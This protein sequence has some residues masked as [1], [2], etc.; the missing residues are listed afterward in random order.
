MTIYVISLH[1]NMHPVGSYFHQPT[2]PRH[3]K[4]TQL[5]SQKHT[6]TMA[7]SERCVRGSVPCQSQALGS[8]G[9]RPW[10]PDSRDILYLFRFICILWC[11]SSVSVRSLSAF[12]V[13]VYVYVY[14]NVYVSIYIYVIILYMYILIYS[15]KYV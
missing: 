7:P 8:L 2:S 1:R 14:V 11:H 4:S 15:T 5:P 3:A 13:H 12:P 6:V 9:S 10:G